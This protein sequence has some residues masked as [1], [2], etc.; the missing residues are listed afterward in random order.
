MEDKATS[1]MGKKGVQLMSHVFILSFPKYVL[2][3][4]LLATWSCKVL[5]LPTI[6]HS[7]GQINTTTVINDSNLTKE[8]RSPISDFWCRLNKEVSCLVLNC[9]PT[10]SQVS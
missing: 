1:A 2:I 5:V 9:F 4:K 10:T 8:R 6:G 3:E 7:T